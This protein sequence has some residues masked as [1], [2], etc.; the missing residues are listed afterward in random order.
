MTMRYKSF[1]FAVKSFEPDEGVFEG[2]AS[3]FGNVDSYGDTVFKGAFKKTIKENL[4]NIKILRQHDSWGVVG[5]PEMLK[6]TN[7]GLF[8]RGRIPLDN[9]LP[10]SRQ[11]YAELKTGLLDG[12]SIGYELVP[13]KFEENDTGGFDLHEIK[14]WEISAVTWGADAFARVSAVKAQDLAQMEPAQLRSLL[15][16]LQALLAKVEPAPATPAG[17]AAAS[18]GSDP[19]TQS[20]PQLAALAADL[21]ASI[22]LLKETL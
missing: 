2:M 7:E 10:L 11:T 22:K 3:T 17:D 4:A 18:T 15:D 6:E 12:L 16:E 9:D 21:N 14:L 19:L 20:L 13:G 1:P 5:L 8:L